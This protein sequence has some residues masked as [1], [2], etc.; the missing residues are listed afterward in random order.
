[1]LES[2]DCFTWRLYGAATVLVFFF[3][4]LKSV[5]CGRRIS[6]VNLVT[7]ALAGCSRV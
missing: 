6:I 3:P 1:M 5:G 7:I 2:D 4:P